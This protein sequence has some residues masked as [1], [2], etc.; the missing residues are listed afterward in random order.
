VSIDAWVYGFENVSM[1]H[2]T[3]VPRPSAHLQLDDAAANMVHRLDNRTAF[4]GVVDVHSNSLSASS[5]AASAT[6]IH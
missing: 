3:T 6:R 4:D 1:T 5:I 2:H